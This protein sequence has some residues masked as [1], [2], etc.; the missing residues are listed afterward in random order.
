MRN[1]GMM[2][3]LVVCP[4][5]EPDTAPTGVVIT[6]L[7]AELASLGHE[8]H[9]VT[10]LPWYRE[11]R[12][13][14][15]WRHVTWSSRTAETDWGSVTRLNPF[16][17]SDKRNIFRRALGFIG[18]T[19]TSAV[20]AFLVTRRRRIDAVIVMSPPLTLGLG[21]GVVAFLRRVPMILNIQDVFPDAAVR[22]GAISNS[23]VIRAAQLLERLTYRAS[24]VVTV[25]S[26]D[27]G[28]NVRRKLPEG[29]R[30]KVEVIPN[31]V[32]AE[33]IEPRNRLTTYRSEL[34]I[35]DQPVVM[36]AGNVG[37]SQSLELMIRAAQALPEIVFVINGAGSARP[38]LEVEARGVANVVFG[39]FQPVERLAEVLCTADL[40][41]VALHSGLGHVSV[42]SKTYSILAAGRPILAS[43]DQGTE[44]PRL[45]ESSGAG[46]SVLPD[47]EQEFIEA[48]RVLMSDR[49]ALAEMGRKG[50]E[51][52]ITAKSPRQIGELYE[53]LIRRCISR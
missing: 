51:F 36:Y 47:N 21:T 12:I 52:I 42:P 20:A 15:G 1:D 44:I 43:I 34:G 25:L 48:V 9:V 33:A 45:L 46:V 18:F 41:V 30:D 13:D 2:R 4:H 28:D 31:F 37:F 16:A 26:E 29:S 39:D 17:G 38:R 19:L 40:H 14:P 11:H 10:S 35:G 32:D 23:L 53:S 22:T 6:R 7:V 5:F 24:T 49:P 27:L 8:I 50:R 3:I